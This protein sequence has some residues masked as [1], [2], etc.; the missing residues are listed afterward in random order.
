MG[1]HGSRFRRYFRVP[2]VPRGS[3]GFHGI[4]VGLKRGKGVLE[5]RVVIRGITR[6]RRSL[7]GGIMVI[8]RIP[9]DFLMSLKVLKGYRE[10]QGHFTGLRDVAGGLRYVE[11]IIR[12]VLQGFIG[13]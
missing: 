12:G 11:R 3:R 2:G 9:K 1:F 7:F 6:G 13:S 8:L 10:S 5:F 4:S